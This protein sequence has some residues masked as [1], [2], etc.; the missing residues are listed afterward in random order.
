MLFLYS[1]TNNVLQKFIYSI[2]ISLISFA[3]F[4]QNQVTGTVTDAYT[5]QP[6]A[7]ANIIYAGRTASTNTEGDF[8]IACGKP[9]PLTISFVGYE[10]YRQPVKNCGTSFRI[11]LVPS[12]KNLDEVEITAT[13]NLN[14]SLLYQPTSIS[15][16]QVT[17]LKR[18]TGL[19]LDD[20]I[21]GNVPGV[22]MNRRAVSSG[23]QFNIRGYGNG[24][25]GTR[26]ISSNFDG[27]GYKV[28][29][30]GIP[31]TDAEG[32][33]V[34]DDIDFGSIGNVEVTKGPAG[35]LYG[36]AIAGVVNLKT[37][38]LVR[39]ATSLSQEVLF[40]NY[41][42]KRYTTQ[43]QM[44]A[45]RSAILLNYGHQESDGFTIHN[46]SKKNFV[47]AVADFQPNT[48]QSFSAYMGYSNSYDER[49]GELTIAQYNAN[50]FSGNIEYIKRN[51][52]SNVYTVRAGV[53]HTYNFNNNIANTTNIFGTAFNSNVSSAGG[54][55]DKSST[56]LGI[57]S[58][59]D[60]KFSLRN[61]ISLSGI[62][63]VESQ[64][65]N[66]QTIGYTMVKNPLDTA[67][68]WK[69]GNPY[70]WV[71]GAS[72]SNVY[73]TTAT[74]SVFTE[75]TLA[76]PKDLSVTAG[77]GLS[78]ML[79]KLEDRF[80]VANKP[81]M[82]DTSY[83]GML[84][85]HVAI[86]KV[87]NKQFS[88]FASY[89]KA[90]KAPVSSYFFIPYSTV[91]GTSQSG[92]VN[93]HL[94]PESANQFEIGTKGVLLNS[95]LNYQLVFFDAIFSDKMTT[96]AVPFNS[97]TT[98][99]SYVTNGGKQ[100]DKGIEAAVKYTAYESSKGFFKSIT[101]FT[102][103][104]YSDFEYKDFRFQTIGKTTVTPVKDSAFT[105]DYSG[106]AVAGVAKF[107]GN[108]GVDINTHPG[109]YANV[110]YLYKDGMPITSD[111]S[112]STSSYSLLNAKIGYQHSFSKHFDLNVYF[113]GANITN[114]KYPIMVFVNQLPDA[115]IAA[116]KNANVFGGLNLKYNF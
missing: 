8:S 19:F 58:T 82:Y 51:A 100:D 39:G 64:R 13:S 48:K 20:A 96:V 45:E 106:H 89:S 43:F 24:S 81:T 40:G 95:K 94:K 30:N 77:I 65:Q 38:K 70:Y 115:Y 114:A 66:A 57:R 6:L 116:P 21:N 23:Q 14:K 88:L 2:F 105:T 31:V 47:N 34:L 5:G 83:K 101:P 84:S 78:N 33:T 108:I 113:G 11:L 68:T 91:G 37:I 103:A 86:N 60:T 79:I 18:G 17:E 44:G 7:G 55:T 15:K 74:T 104:T 12:N 67:S 26:G 22:T 56:N 63:G 59:F 10:T 29:L 69:Y 112:F 32:I 36:L 90:Y 102:N 53:G 87:F 62:T 16:L 76:L 3:G 9:G 35:T 25:R 75:W 46:A 54:W 73:T 93:R 97:T 49:S 85:P 27:Q 4:A 107:M 98:L 71:L 42:L 52:H 99:Y 110:T 1:K 111:G 80:Y 92:L 72:N 50:D 109:F 41:G 61:N 28:Y